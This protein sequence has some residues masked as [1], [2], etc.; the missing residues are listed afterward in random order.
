M[1]HI[2][3]VQGSVQKYS[4]NF[5]HVTQPRKSVEL[6]TKSFSLCCTSVGDLMSTENLKNVSVRKLGLQLAV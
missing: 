5:C 2:G 3:M 6:P 1:V 4:S